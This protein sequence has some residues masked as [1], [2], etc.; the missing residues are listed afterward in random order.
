MLSQSLRDIVNNHE[1]PGARV[2][3][4]EGVV[5]MD[6]M[7][8]SMNNRDSTSPNM[9]G[10]LPHPIQEDIVTSLEKLYDL[11]TSRFEEEYSNLPSVKKKILLKQLVED[12]VNFGDEQ[13]DAEDCPY[14]GHGSDEFLGQ[15]GAAQHIVSYRT[16]DKAPE[17]STRQSKFVDI[18][19]FNY[20]LP[21]IDN[22]T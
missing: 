6:T 16:T 1:M 22:E 13:Q 19:R 20:S 7:M 4:V 12:E 3:A 18:S 17:G 9:K 14:G 8:Q 2:E 15:A 5:G 11:D 10:H 21:Q